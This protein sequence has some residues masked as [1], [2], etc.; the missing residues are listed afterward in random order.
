[1]SRDFDFIA[2]G[3]GSGGFNA[4][5]V[6]RQFSERVAIIDGAAQLGG[7]CILRGCMPSKTLLYPTHILHLAQHGKTFGLDIP[8]AA[9]DMPALAARKR[10]IIREFADYREKAM[11]SGR[12]T[13]LRSFARFIDPHTL[14]LS[15]GSK[16]TAD[17][18]LIGTGSIVSRPP[19]P[20]L[21]HPE[22]WTSDE[23]LDL[24]QVP[25]SV[26]VLGG[27]VVACELA[28][29]L[30]RIGSKVT[31][32]QRSPRLLRGL[33]TDAADVVA[34]AFRR[35]GI[36]LR[37]GT[38]LV[39]LR[40]T[41]SGFEV[42]FEQ[43]GQR[44]TATARHVLNALGRVPNTSGLGL[45]AAGVD[46]LPSGH[47]RVNAHQQS[48]APHI[49]AAGD[50]TGPHEIVHIAVQQG[51]L[52]ARHAFGQASTPVDY[53]QL[54]TVVF[55]DPAVAQCGIMPAQAK[56][57]GIEVVTA[58]YPFDDH[59]KSILMEEKLGY[60]R[61]H[62]DKRDGRILGAEIAGPEAG[63]LIHCLTVAI[64]LKATAADLLRAP[65]YHPTLAEILTYPL[66]DIV[67]AT[68]KG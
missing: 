12:F 23:V 68:T 38:H 43:H 14:L 63:E 59:G 24:T 30:V 67:E 9:V 42:T 58:S 8:K 66:E 37:L 3:G 44:H 34:T 26:I 32:I 52:A 13:V 16:V 41:N 39:G 17:R 2:I 35:E 6:A 22:I 33:S 55:T 11:L 62:A 50:C 64:A 49:Y 61:M 40:K 56:D 36:D 46:L 27:G 7:L 48:T 45:E 15:D 60:V 10:A 5:R 28:Q 4:A 31:Q 29:F 57:R 1:M 18:F 53:D 25:E 65:W 47:I 21:E 20:G 54:V 19:V 51:E